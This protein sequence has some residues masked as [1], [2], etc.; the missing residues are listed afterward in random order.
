V[1][2]GAAGLAAA[3]A[4]LWFGLH[5]AT[6]PPLEGIKFQDVH[7][8]MRDLRE[9]RGKVVVLNF[10]ATWC[11]PCREEIPMLIQAH[12]SYRPQ[13][14]EIVGIAID[15]ASKVLE[16]TKTF[17]INYPILVADASGL[18]LVRQLGNAS[19][20]LPYTVFVDRDGRPVSSKVGALKRADLDAALSKIGR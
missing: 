13:G 17:Q 1:L 3:L 5:T 16:F 19:G 14:V 11:A 6:P 10:W 12:E 8:N 20:G 15:N 7:G 18:D 9:W 2:L 4:G